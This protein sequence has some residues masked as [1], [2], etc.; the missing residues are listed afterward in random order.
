MDLRHAWR[1]LLRAP[2]F[3]ITAVGT[4]ALAIGAVAGMFGVVNTVILK[5]LPFPAADRLV[6]VSG[7]APG[8][9]LPET[10]GLGLE[11]YFH[12]REHSKLIDGIF[13]FDGGTSTFRT[14]TRVE[15]IPMA[16][17]SNDMYHTLGVRPQLGRV[18]VSEDGERVVLISD[19]LWASWFGRD[20]SVVGKTYFVSGMMREIIGVM[21]SEFRFPFDDTMLWVAGDR[22]LAQVT[23]GQLGTPVV[24]RMKA[25]VTRDQLA[26]ELT[27]LSKELPARFG[28]PPT[29]AGFIAQHRAVVDPVLDRLVGPT[30]RTSLWVLLAAVSIVLV[31]ACANV[32]NLFLVR[33]EGRRRDMAIRHA[34]GASRTQLVRLQMAEAL[35]VA[36]PAGVLAVVLATVT[37]PL[38]VRA[39]PGDIPRL[40]AVGLDLATVAAAFGLVVIVDWRAVWGPPCGHRH[41]ISTACARAGA[42]RRAGGA[43]DATSSSSGRRRSRW[44]CSSAPRC[45]CRAF[46]GCG[47]STPGTTPRTSTPSS[48]RRRN[49]TSWTARASADCI[50]ISWTGCAR[51]PG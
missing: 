40:A 41:R 27:R 36:L 10:F 43:G 32:A 18:P 38:F 4:L 49:R 2:G 8:S 39:A 35:L 6:V 26:A 51:S 20:P 22:Q 21:P 7:T 46:S 44:C 24:A 9:D 50:S 13:V 42:E 17:P 3:L 19:Q 37:L 25:G 16:F 34:M 31:I 15:R 28:G 45:W 47:T 12:Y 14:D 30:L 23:A 11:F 48:S 29:Y 33:A 1:A 5:P